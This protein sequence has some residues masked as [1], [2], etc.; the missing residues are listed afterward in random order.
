[1]CEDLRTLACKS[2]SVNANVLG[3]HP[4]SGTDACHLTEVTLVFRFG[5]SLF[6]SALTSLGSVAVHFSQ[7]AACAPGT[8]SLYQ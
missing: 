1:M 5:G 3:T 8:S 7:I 6:T 4:V 2:R